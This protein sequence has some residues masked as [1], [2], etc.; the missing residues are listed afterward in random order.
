MSGAGSSRGPGS[1][2]NILPMSDLKLFTCLVPLALL[3]SSCGANSQD[4]SAVSDAGETS[5]PA[6][7]STIAASPTTPPAVPTATPVPPYP[8]SPLRRLRIPNLG[9]DAAI[10][11]I[12]LTPDNQLD[13]PTKFETE[14]GWYRIYAAPNAAGNA[15]F[16]GVHGPGRPFDR[17]TEL[18]VGDAIELTMADG[19]V[20]AYAVL[21]RTRHPKA[22][23]PM[24]DIILPSGRTADSQWITLLTSGG[25]PDSTGE[26]Q[27]LDV[28]TA[29]RVN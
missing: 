27:D 14:V 23:A 25:L 5:A 18:K 4:T 21:G 12:G 9:V 15:I 8:D 2:S 29:Q 19:T 10:Q 24:A 1:T 11:P 6:S 13:S 28:V 26:P 22:A 3:F 7:V 20:V 16:A 17:L